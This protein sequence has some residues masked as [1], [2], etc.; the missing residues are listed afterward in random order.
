[1]LSPRDRTV[2][3]PPREGIDAMLSWT[4]NSTNAFHRSL[5]W[6]TIRVHVGA[7]RGPA[8][9]AA[10]ARA[11][12]VVRILMTYH[13][14]SAQPARGP[15]A[16]ART[17]RSLLPEARPL[18]REFVSVGERY[19]ANRRAWRDEFPRSLVGVCVAAG[20]VGVFLAARSVVRMGRA[21]RNAMT[22]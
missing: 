16:A 5:V 11:Q 14:L 13:A 18:A 20:V 8:W 17:L 21:A 7:P 3:T 19:L 12:A 6:S 2:P 1:E 9:T 4:I 10:E 15:A 22:A